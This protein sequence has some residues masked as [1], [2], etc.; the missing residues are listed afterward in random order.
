MGLHFKR[1]CPAAIISVTSVAT[2]TIHQQKFR[3]ILIGQPNI[4]ISIESRTVFMQRT[5]CISMKV[6]KILR[7]FV[8]SDPSC[9]FHHS[10]LL[11][12]AP[13]SGIILHAFLAFQRKL[14]DHIG[15]GRIIFKPNSIDTRYFASRWKSVKS[16]LNIIHQSKLKS[17]YTWNLLCLKSIFVDLP[18]IWLGCRWLMRYA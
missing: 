1:C 7:F 10:T 2:K 5:K 4:N 12:T 14:F 9:L 13:Q 11:V 18:S 6:S 8:V 3:N 17:E 15:H 16:E